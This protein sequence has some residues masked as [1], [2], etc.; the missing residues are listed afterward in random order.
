MRLIPSPQAAF[1]ATE[2][3]RSLARAR[4]RQAGRS[5]AA[6]K[7]SGGEACAIV[8]IIIIISHSFL[9]FPFPEEDYHP[10]YHHYESP[11]LTYSCR[12]RDNLASQ[13]EDAQSFGRWIPCPFPFH[14]IFAS[15][16]PFSPPT[17]IPIRSAAISTPPT[18]CITNAGLDSK[19]NPPHAQNS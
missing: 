11:H 15:S 3:A 16:Q 6:V 13:T 5:K 2:A 4:L 18:A 10:W 8:V 9:F 1:K 17:P 19:L 12:L 7:D 14:S